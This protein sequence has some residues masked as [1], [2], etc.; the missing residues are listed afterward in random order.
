[1]NANTAAMYQGQLTRILHEFRCDLP[2]YLKI[3]MIYK[4]YSGLQRNTICTAAGLSPD[5]TAHPG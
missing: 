1:M 3:T 4:R 2:E 5:C